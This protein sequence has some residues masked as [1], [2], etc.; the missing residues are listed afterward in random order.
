[1]NK[2]GI[3]RKRAHWRRKSRARLSRSQEST[4]QD[5]LW[6]FWAKE[7]SQQYILMN[8]MHTKIS[9]ISL[10]RRSVTVTHFLRKYAVSLD[11]SI[12]REQKEAMTRAEERKWK[13][14]QWHYLSF[15]AVWEGRGGPEGRVIDAPCIATRI[16]GCRD[17]A[18]WERPGQSWQLT[19]ENYEAL[20]K[21]KKRVNGSQTSKTEE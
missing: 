4:R 8:F 19:D 6:I 2:V 15:R 11:A 9:F 21:T 20:K 3:I 5:S 18:C 16:Y 13:R 14:A 1:M 12:W 7:S 10:T 17:R